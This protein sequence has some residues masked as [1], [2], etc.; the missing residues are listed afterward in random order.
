MQRI[1][2]RGNLLKEILVFMS[3]K[4]RHHRIQPRQY[5]NIQTF[6][7]KLLLII[8]F[9]Q[10]NPSCK[11]SCTWM[12]DTYQ[13][14]DIEDLEIFHFIEFCTEDFEGEKF[15]E[16]DVTEFMV[17]Y[18]GDRVGEIVEAFVEFGVGQP[19]AELFLIA[20]EGWLSNNRYQIHNIQIR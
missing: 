10:G 12:D 4:K 15:A 18:N 6:M 7:I 14:K 16:K 3:I 1:P 5:R 20:K 17:G 9:S 11:Y 13:W 19:C 2:F 8:S